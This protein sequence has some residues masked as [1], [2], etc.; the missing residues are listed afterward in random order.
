MSAQCMTCCCDNA[1]TCKTLSV[2]RSVSACTAS[3]SRARLTSCRPD[4]RS[5]VHFRSSFCVGIWLCICID[6]LALKLQT[7]INM[8]AL[9]H[10][11]AST[12]QYC[13]M[14]VCAADMRWYP[15]LHDRAESST[16]PLV[17]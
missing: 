13:P 7:L 2:A 9:R 17:P 8:L 15:V 12:L 1:A 14:G 6:E 5:A 16:P 3:A 11:S 4:A 10:V